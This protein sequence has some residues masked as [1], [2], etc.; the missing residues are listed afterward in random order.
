M[1]TSMITAA[2]NHAAILHGALCQPLPFVDVLCIVH[3]CYEG[4]IDEWAKVLVSGMR[5]I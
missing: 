4:P 2:A 3:S 1:G 5:K